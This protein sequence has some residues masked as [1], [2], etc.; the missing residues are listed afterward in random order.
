MINDR[1][2]REYDIRGIAGVDLNSEAAIAVGKAFGLF[3]K[4]S[5]PNARRVSVGRDVRHSSEDLADGI[6]EGFISAGL[7][8]CDIGVCPTPVQY[9]SLFD[10][11]LDGGIM[12]TGSHNPPE[13]NGFKLSAGKKTIHGKDIQKLKE[14]INKADW[15]PAERAG[16]IERQDTVKAYK[17]YMLKEFSYLNDSRYKKL[18]II[19]DAGNGTAGPIVPEILSAIGCEVIPLFCELK[20]RVDF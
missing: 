7:D 14:I 16:T 17:E 20:V 2:F 12:V 3:L 6:K 13:Y 5:N 8:V 11:D 15:K 10:L 18:K 9:F 19:V 4:E 1:I